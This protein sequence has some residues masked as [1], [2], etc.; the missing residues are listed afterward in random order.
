MRIIRTGCRWPVPSSGQVGRFVKAL[1]ERP[2]VKPP[3]VAE[4]LDF[5]Q[6]LLRLEVT[7]LEPEVVG[8]TPRMPPERPA[9]S[10]RAP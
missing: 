3:G 7:R 9:G 10:R 8:R 4:T 2:L 5:T 1:R 6:A